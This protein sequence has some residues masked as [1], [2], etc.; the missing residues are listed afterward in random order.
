MIQEDDVID[1]VANRQL[2]G[3]IAAGIDGG[4][5]QMVEL[6]DAMDAASKYIVCLRQILYARDADV[7]K[8]AKDSVNRLGS[9][10]SVHLSKFEKLPQ[11]YS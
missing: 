2:A 9:K 1:H 8:N 3:E 11:R 6:L 5:D 10:W 4:Y 7:L